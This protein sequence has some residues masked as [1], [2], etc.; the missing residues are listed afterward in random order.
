M[1][2][3]DPVH[4]GKWDDVDCAL[5]RAYLCQRPVGKFGL[6]GERGGGKSHPQNDWGWG[7][8]TLIIQAYRMMWIVHYKEPISA[9]DQWISCLGWD[10][11]SHPQ[12]DFSKV[13]YSDHPDQWD[14][15]DCVL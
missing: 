14:N 7:C 10:G 6:D 15:V 9:K 13:S 1:T 12:I 8:P 5:Q 4:P 11:E 3:I 2:N